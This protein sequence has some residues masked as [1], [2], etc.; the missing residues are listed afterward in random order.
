[1]LSLF[2]LANL[3]ILSPKGDGEVVKLHN[4]KRVR[5][6]YPLTLRE[7]DDKSVGIIPSAPFYM[8]SKVDGLCVWPRRGSGAAPLGSVDASSFNS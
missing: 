7:L 2:C 4:L 1:V 8:L 5:E 6:R 3:A